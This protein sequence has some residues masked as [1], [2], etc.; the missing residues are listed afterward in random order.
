MKTNATGTMSK[1]VFKPFAE[2]KAAQE[3]AEAKAKAAQEAL[4]ARKKE[5]EA[6]TKAQL[7]EQYPDAEG[8]TKAEL[9]DSIRSKD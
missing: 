6:L 1:G 4:E 3:R 7:E 5:L 9:I 2:A 8:N